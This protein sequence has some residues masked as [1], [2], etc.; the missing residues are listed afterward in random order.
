[1]GMLVGFITNGPT[2]KR[3]SRRGARVGG[4]RPRRLHTSPRALSLS[5]SLQNGQFMTFPEAVR[6]FREGGGLPA[7]ARAAVFRAMYT[8]H[9]VLALNFM[10]HKVEAATTASSA[11]AR[12]ARVARAPPGRPRPVGG[13]SDWRAPRRANRFPVAKQTAP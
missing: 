7:P 12:P 10:R 6:G 13:A 2:S 11:S 5:P 4:R 8:G 3:A 1:M 9:G